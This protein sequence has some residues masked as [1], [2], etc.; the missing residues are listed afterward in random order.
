MSI[1]IIIDGYNLIRQSDAL[2]IL[3]QQDIQL[4]RDALLDKLAIYKK[5]KHHR[6]TVVFDGASA[7][8]F[9]QHKDRIQGIEV[10]FSRRGELADTVIKNMAAM[11]REKALIVSSDHDIINF[12]SNQGAATISSPVFEKK[13]DM[14]EYMAVKGIDMESE[15]N[16]GWIPT[17]KKNGPKKRLSKK[18]RRSRIKIRKL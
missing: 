14:A 2:N 7:P 12:A 17:T 3:D 16:T 6:I 5:I 1:H 18:D 13:I 10:R 9:T 8:S 15:K 4:G 11:E